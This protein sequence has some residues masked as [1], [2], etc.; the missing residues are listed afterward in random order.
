M[1]NNYISQCLLLIQGSESELFQTGHVTA[2][3]YN[4]LHC[5]SY[6]SDWRSQNNKITEKVKTLKATRLRTTGR[7]DAAVDGA[8]NGDN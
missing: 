1:S 3:I 7:I 6:L 4:A 2:D 5:E 8:K